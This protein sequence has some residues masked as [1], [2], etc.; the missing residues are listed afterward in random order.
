MRR[1]SLVLATMLLAACGS[2]AGGGLGDVLGGILG[3]PSAEQPSDVR[4]VVRGVDTQ[5][6]RIDLDPSYIN[7]LRDNSSD[8][9][10]VYYDANTQVQYNN[11]TYNV[12]ALERGDEITIRG[13]NNNGRYV[14]TVITVTRDASQ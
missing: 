10:A 11:Q 2:G 3:S 8:T 4:G 7:N 1:A 5:A 13:A 6:M 12:T 14:A 9:A